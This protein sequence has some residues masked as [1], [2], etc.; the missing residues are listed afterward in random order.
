MMAKFL[1]RVLGYFLI[2]IIIGRLLFRGFKAPDYWRRWS[3]RFGFFNSFSSNKRIWIH[4][5]SFGE[6]QASVPL[7]KA[8]Q[9]K[10]PSYDFLITTMT[11]TGAQRAKELFGETIT[12]LYLPYDVW[13]AVF[14]FLH[15]TKPTIGIIIETELWFNLFQACKKR[16]IPLFLVNAR[17]SEKSFQKYQKFIPNL[18]KQTL[19]CLTHIAAQTIDDQRRLES[20]GANNITITGSLKFDV[21]IP[22]SIFEKAKEL[23]KELENRKIWIAA[24]T[25]EGEETIILNVH[26]QIQRKMPN[27]LL[28][29]V[30]RHPERFNQIF[31]LCEQREFKTSRR[32]L[33]QKISEKTEIYVG[34]TMGELLMLYAAADVAFVG[35][36]LISRG[37]HNLLEPA[38]IGKPILT[39]Q[40]MFN[41]A[42][43]TKRLLEINAAEQIYDESQLVERLLFLLE[44]PK[45][46]EEM[47]EKGK[48]FVEKNRGALERVLNLIQ[49]R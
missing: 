39:G 14:L 27:V 40:F 49:I 12:H 32:S 24:S 1:Y 41:F 13:H 6:V 8:L 36:S 46:R 22:A 18:T 31:Q 34:D 33:S 23:K 20:L 11:P 10:Y 26:R 19:Q 16:H 25:H 44:N 28:I 35:G 43:I 45:S 30:P 48:V 21:E 2:P 3:E 4:A 47:G 15:K 7:I 37:G 29:L 38:A 5:V 42:E 17:L 9:L